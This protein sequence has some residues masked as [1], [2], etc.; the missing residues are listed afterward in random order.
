MVRRTSPAGIRLT[1]IDRVLTPPMKG[2]AKYLPL[3]FGNQRS[4]RRN[5]SLKAVRQHLQT[6]AGGVHQT[7]SG[8]GGHQ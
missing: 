8:H 5:K 6:V 2:V 4:V 1:S 3:F 7:R